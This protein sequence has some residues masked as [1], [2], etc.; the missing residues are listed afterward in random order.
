MTPRHCPPRKTLRRRAEA[1]SGRA[2]KERL[3]WGECICPQHLLTTVLWSWPWNPPR[4]N[5]LLPE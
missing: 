5:T 1:A 4:G 3:T 2:E